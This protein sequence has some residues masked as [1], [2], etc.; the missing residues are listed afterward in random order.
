MQLRTDI[1]RREVVDTTAMPWVASPS[2]GVERR[3]LERQGDEVAR[4]TTVVRYAPGSRFATHTHDMGEEFLVLDGVFQDEHGDY[5]AG[6]YVRNPWGT[7]H[8]PRS[9]DGC[10]ILVKL[11]Q[12]HPE[13]Q[14][15]VAT[16]IDDV[17]ATPSDAVPGLS[18][19]PLHR[20]GAEQVELEVWS[21]GSGGVE[22]TW[23]HGA[24]LFVLDGALADEDGTYGA[25]T[26]IR[27]PPG[28]THTPTAPDGARV[29]V[30]H[31]HLR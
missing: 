11:R 24:E 6:A 28:S 12:M 20:F 22:R 2:P 30:K 10:T 18:R 8:A 15:R 17:A 14:A 5:P 25:G 21:P 7:S 29:W 4:A 27:I 13:D 16:H 31:G 9:A 1:S 26:W 3:M 19:R 23:D